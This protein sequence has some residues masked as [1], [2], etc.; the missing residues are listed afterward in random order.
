MQ[1]WDK[2]GGNGWAAK[3]LP[4]ESMVFLLGYLQPAHTPRELH[5]I[6]RDTGERVALHAPECNVTRMLLHF[7]PRASNFSRTAVPAN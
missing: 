7:S 5:P 1:R 4:E 2:R 3:R 6:T